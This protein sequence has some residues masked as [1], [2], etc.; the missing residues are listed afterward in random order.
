M[1]TWNTK[2]QFKQ[3]KG[4]LGVMGHIDICG[5]TYTEE[6]KRQSEE[7]DSERALPSYLQ[8]VT[9]QGNESQSEH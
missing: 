3:Q 2:W 4:K 8:L 7:G 9:K 1:Q 5:N 6:E